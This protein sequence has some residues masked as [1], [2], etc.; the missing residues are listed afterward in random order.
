MRLETYKNKE[1]EEITDVFY[2]VYKLFEILDEKQQKSPWIKRLKRCYRFA[3]IMDIEV[4]LDNKIKMIFYDIP[5]KTGGSLD[6][7]K[8]LEN[9]K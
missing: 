6:V 2:I 3:D 1:V 7:Y 5:C 9:L 8:I 4:L